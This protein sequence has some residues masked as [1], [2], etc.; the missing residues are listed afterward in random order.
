MVIISNIYFNNAL[1][2][3]IIIKSQS[4]EHVGFS[5]H[6]SSVVLH[7]VKGQDYY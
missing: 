4:A 5:L 6:E 1:G 7:I 2:I 3:I